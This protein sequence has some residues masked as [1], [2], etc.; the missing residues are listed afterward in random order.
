M[1]PAAILAQ[2]GRILA[3]TEP[4]EREMPGDVPNASAILGDW[5][6]AEVLSDVLMDRGESAVLCALAALTAELGDPYAAAL[7]LFTP[8]KAA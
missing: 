5:R 4:G 2:L 3:R 1:I 8:S 7:R 6:I